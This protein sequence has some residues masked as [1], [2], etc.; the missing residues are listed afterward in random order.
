MKKTNQLVLAMFAMTSSLFV[1]CIDKSYDLSDVDMLVG[2]SGDITL[3]ICSTDEILLSNVMDLEDDDVV[4][5][6][7]GEFFIVSDGSA[8]VPQV[9]VSDISINKPTLTDINTTVALD[10]TSESRKNGAFRLPGVPDRTYTYTIQKGDET[11]YGY[12]GETS[13]D[14]PKSV[15]S[16]DNVKF[17][18]NVEVDAKVAVSFGADYRYI[19]K[20]HMDNMIVSVPAGLDVVAASLVYTPK[21]AGVA[22]KAPVVADKDNINN[23]E[24]W[25]RLTAK[26]E[27]FAID[28]YDVSIHLVFNE[29][30]V[31]KGGFHFDGSKVFLDGEFRID[32]T[33]RIESVDFNT[34]KLTA[35]QR[36]IVESENSY[37]GIRPDHVSFIGDAEFVTGDI[38]IGKFTGKFKTD[39]ADIAPF[40]LN[41]M[42]DFLDDPEVVLDLA[43]PTFFIKVNNT[44]ADKATT[45]ITLTSV[46]SD[47]TKSRTRKS[48][49]IT[50][51]AG[52]RIIC[53]AENFDGIKERLPE[54]YREYKDNIVEARIEDLGGLL[55]KIPD[56]IDVDVADLVASM[57][58]VP[59]PSQYDVTVDYMLYT[60]M[61]FGPT[62]NLIYTGEEEDIHKDMEDAGKIGGKEVRITGKV[63][64]DLPLGLTVSVDIEDMDGNSL[65]GKYFTVDN[66]NVKPYK[67]GDASTHEQD[68]TL[69]IKS[70]GENGIQQMLQNM[71]K[72]IY[73]AVAKAD[74]GGKLYENAHVKLHGL[75]F[76]VIG[77][78]T[79][80]AN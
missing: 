74:D 73:R 38:E 57:A 66:I 4:Q 80:D 33:F 45:A 11:S 72:V 25:V 18:E 48:G 12:D 70:V 60:P 42:P 21:H 50:V 51:P 75:K 46:Y 14:V 71:D 10:I 76:T 31:G 6:H 56:E 7:D 55:T 36:R 16:I 62:L 27:G 79:Y 2:T 67:A 13:G 47:G 29:A 49:E 37:D 5:I 61:E 52:V 15:I 35:E 30:E 9:D 19:E 23:E 64:T 68:I 20:V 41:D 22:D 54:A 69:T 24:G 77:G 58:D 17:K 28:D 34:D 43:N 39:I 40:E 26:D 3:P 8:D 1:S 32:G 44:M 63:T 53:L 78:I 65:K 59:V